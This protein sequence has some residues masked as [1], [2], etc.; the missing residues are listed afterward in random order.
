MPNP[1]RE[2]SFL[3]DTIENLLYNKHKNDHLKFLE[4]LVNDGFSI[5]FYRIG[6]DEPLTTIND[7]E[8]FENFKRTR[9]IR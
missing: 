8:H 6:D 4:T 1:E 2:V 7:I 5:T 9:G 3:I